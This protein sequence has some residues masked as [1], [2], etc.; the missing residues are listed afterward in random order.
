MRAAVDPSDAGLIPAS[1]PLRRRALL[2][3]AAGWALASATGNASAH[4]ELGPIEPRR[5]APGLALTLHDG[6]KTTLPRVL[7]GRWTALQLMFTGCSASCPVQGAVFGALQGL[8][9]DSLPGGRHR[10]QEVAADADAQVAHAVEELRQVGV[11]AGG[12]DLVDAAVAQVA[13]QAAGAAQRLAAL[14]VG[15]QL[16]VGHH[17]VHA[18]RQRARHVGAQ[19]QQLGHLLG[20]DDVAV[21]LAVDLEAGDRPQDRAPV[22]EVHLLASRPSRATPAA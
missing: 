5:P 4:G 1:L 10:H 19:D 2:A 17:L 16:Q 21:D 14:L 7:Q 22:I 15:H 6:R 9:L 3:S 8:V 13:L 12:Q 20:P 18:G 11:Q